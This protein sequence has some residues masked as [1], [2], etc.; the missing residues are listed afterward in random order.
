MENFSPK[1]WSRI[2]SIHFSDNCFKANRT[3]KILKEDAVPEI[4]PTFPSHLKKKKNP[5][6]PP[7][8]RSAKSLYAVNSDF[9]K[10]S[11]HHD[12]PY[13]LPSQNDLKRKLEISFEENSQLKKR[14]KLLEAKIASLNDIITEL[15][16][17]N[18][19]NDEVGTI[20]EQ[21]S[22]KVPAEIFERL[23]C[24]KP[25]SEQT[26]ACYSKELK[27]FAVTLQFYSSKAYNYVRNTFNMCLPH[28][29][30]VRRWYTAVDAE[31][32]FTAE[33]FETLKKKTEEEKNSNRQVFVTLTFD[34]MSIRQNLE[35][36]GQKFVGYIDFGLG[37]EGD[38]SSVPATD[39]LVLMVVSQNS[40][41]KLPIAY[42]FVGHCN[43]D[44]KVSILTTALTKLYQIGVIVTC[45]TADGPTTNFSTFKKLGACFDLSSMKSTFPHPC[46][47]NLSV[48]VIMDP[49]HMLKLARNTLADLKV[50][51]DPQG[52]EIKW[53]YIE[54]LHH[55]QSEEG[56]RAGNK[57]KQ[58][59]L[60]WRRMK[61]KVSLAAQTLSRSVADSIDFC[62]ET[63][64][65][66]Q[67]E[68][69]EATSDYIRIIDKLFDICNSRNP[70]GKGSKAPM[71]PENQPEVHAFFEK[72]ESYLSQLKDLKG[73]NLVTTPRKTAFLG[74]IINIH[75]FQFLFDTL[76]QNGPLNYLLTYKCSQDHLELFF[77]ALRGRLGSNNNPSAR[78]FM[79][80]YKRLLLHH[81]IRGNR[82]NCLI[83]D[84]T[85]ILS[86][87]FE[88]KKKSQS[89][90][91]E[92]ALFEKYDLIVDPCDHDYCQIAN[93]PIVTEF[94]TAVMEYIAG[95]AVK[96]ASK[97]IKCDH[98][99]A[100][101]HENHPNTN[102]ALVH[103]KDR[104]GLLHVSPSVRA[105]CQMAEMGVQ[106][107]LKTSQNSLPREHGIL[108]AIASSVMK[109][110]L[111][112]YE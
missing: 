30:T 29:N 60:E 34:E 91:T 65:L 37:V 12:H 81:E 52:R 87:H 50:L 72:S 27:A 74:F 82:G 39:A 41:W 7:P 16:E 107:I 89:I 56:L 38:D 40:S 11:I 59:H 76:V 106:K 44:E 54:K 88:K 8:E 73:K 25:G 63:L 69:S 64:K 94:Q 23:S 80:A 10:N 53:E 55:L 96:M 112:K 26:K 95:Y 47:P 33:A 43:A 100:S 2:C 4:F 70:F 99:V 21:A 67:F 101:I 14:I 28:E 66:P 90:S 51:I 71:K 98:C 108:E 1:N 103:A 111:D 61:M 77:C 84:E 92:S 78:E 42:F 86:F 83:Q 20:L 58:S 102:Y 15:K 19:I 49:C 13:A 79:Q 35:W 46:D 105:V 62:R 36:D 45:A 48:A 68:D 24:S 31:P 75:S 6:K 5:R 57:L 3:R 109:N 18:L 22:L 110:V 104:G 85:S 9:S 17:K 32:G 93:L 97:C